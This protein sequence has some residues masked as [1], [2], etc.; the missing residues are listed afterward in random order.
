[1]TVPS[2]GSWDE[3][4][5]ATGYQVQVSTSEDFSGAE[6]TDVEGTSHAV[7]VDAGSTSYLRVRA[8]GAGDPGAWSTHVTGMSNAPPE[9]DPEVPDPIDVSFS[10]ADEE[11]GF[12]MEPDDSDD[13]EE[14]TASVNAKMVVS[15]NY[16]I[17]ITPT[18]VE[19]AAAVNVA[20][21][22]NN[23][24]FAY[25]DWDA[26]Q[27]DVV[28]GGAIF[29]IQK[30]A[31]GANQQMEPTG[32]VAYVAC[33]PFECVSGDSSDVTAPTIT[34]ADDDSYVDWDP[35]LDVSYGWVDNDVF[36]AD[37]AG[38]MGATGMDSAAVVD[39]GI[40]L[41]WTTSS[42]LGMG[43]K[44][45][46]NGVPDG[47][48]FSVT[49]PDAMGDKNAK[50]TALAV[51]VEADDTVDPAVESNEA[52]FNGVLTADCIATGETDSP[53]GFMVD[54]QGMTSGL[55]EPGGCF[56]IDAKPD[57]LSGYSLE[58]T[59]QNEGVTW[60][61]VG[62]FD[63][64]EYESR[65]VAAADVVTDICELFEA[66][67]E[68]VFEDDWTS[69]EFL[70]RETDPVDGDG[71]DEEYV[72]NWQ[73]GP[74]DISGRQFKTLWFDDDLDGDLKVKDTD[75]G[76]T[77]FVA[78]GANDLYDQAEVEGNLIR[79]SQSIID[80]DKDPTLGDFGKVDL[81]GAADAD[82]D[83]P[84]E[85]G[86][87]GEGD[88]MTGA[89]ADE[90]ECTMDDNGDDQEEACDAMFEMEFPIYF[91]DGT[92]GCEIT[93][94]VTVTCTWDAQGDVL[95]TG[96]AANDLTESNVADNWANC[97]AEMN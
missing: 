17:A 37:A 36:D 76:P 31:E 39:D 67:V 74:G 19:G 55:G 75:K 95:E 97:T 70:I 21:G 52:D 65:T 24:P 54:N 9:P 71:G 81:V 33:G 88:N 5:G 22:D 44:H 41:G 3:V 27:S 7:D 43:V 61:E 85:E 51:L 35:V 91:T 2:P 79:I 6:T 68:M 59:P 64:L 46:F 32:D 23:M 38:V 34:I 20:A 49:G 1:M 10:I 12:P 83:P 63:D 57:W 30:R 48:N 73:V 56:K 16:P 82:A 89:Q 4:E 13:E 77:P 50:A 25:V 80:D 78:K 62:W 66:E 72:E 53:Y 87:D 45:I 94:D 86:P 29:M 60:G 15:S 93:V 8:T 26:P 14:A 90:A 40:E 96:T 92:F 28:D 84:V 69:D 58:F 11:D 18:F 42:T 47:R